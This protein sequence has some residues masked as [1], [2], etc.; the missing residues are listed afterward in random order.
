MFSRHL[1]FLRH[2]SSSI[3]RWHQTQTN[4]KSQP[5]I[6]HSKELYNWN[7]AMTQSNKQ[8]TPKNT[9]ALFDHLINQHPDITPNFITYLLALTACIRLGNL[10]EGK[11]IHEYIRQKRTT[12]IERNEDVKV[13]TCLLQLYATCGDL[14]TGRSLLFHTN[15]PLYYFVY[16]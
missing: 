9:L 5:F 6:S 15:K 16:L 8:N 2:F 3:V 11:R 12:S 7:I 10:T 1:F 4:V 14:R 13:H